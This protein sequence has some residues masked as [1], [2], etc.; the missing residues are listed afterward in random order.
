MIRSLFVRCGE[1]NKGARRP[2]TCRR[3]QLKKIGIL[4]AGF[5]GAGIAY[6]SALAGLEV[7]LIDRDQDSADKGKAHS[8]KLMTEQVNRGRATTADRDALLARITPTPDYNAL[9]GLRSR[10]RGGVRGPQGQGRGDRQ[11]AGRDAAT[12]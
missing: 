12:R 9:Q 5:M 4:G 7:V 2:A 10:H 3:R 6:V 8:Q 1:L 11:G